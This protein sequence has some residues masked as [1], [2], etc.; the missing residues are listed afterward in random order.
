[1]NLNVQ[2]KLTLRVCTGS[3]KEQSKFQTSVFPHFFYYTSIFIN[4]GF[5][6]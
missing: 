5:K 2:D 4:N 3:L 1:M 6:L